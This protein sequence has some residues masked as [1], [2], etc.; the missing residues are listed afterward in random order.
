MNMNRNQTLA[1][2]RRE[3]DA[4][5]KAQSVLK[6]EERDIRNTIAMLE[7]RG[8][9]YKPDIVRKKNAKAKGKGKPVKARTMSPEARER[10][11]AAQVKRWANIRGEV[12]VPE[13]PSSE[14]IQ[15]AAD[16]GAQTVS[17]PVSD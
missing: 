10:I 7:R 11:R 8:G 9:G 5:L 1:G 3:L 4:T 15:A 6:L 17:E 2:L 14:Q 13:S 12:V 16:S